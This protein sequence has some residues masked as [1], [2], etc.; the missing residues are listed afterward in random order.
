MAQPT[1]SDVHVDSIL[2]SVSVAY[3]QSQMA[4]IARRVFPL[5]PVAKQ[6]DKYYVYGA[7]AWVR[8]EAQ[9]RAP[10]TESAGGGWTVSTDSYYA[11]VYAIHKDIDEQLVANADGN[12]DPEGEAA[13]YVVDQILRKMEVDFA[14][15]FLTTGVWGSSVTPGTLWDNVASDP[16]WDIALGKRTVL[17]NTGFEPNVGVTTP[18]VFDALRLHPDVKDQFKHTTSESITADMLARV[19]GLD[20]LI[21]SK[22]IKAT[23]NE[24][25]TLATSFI[26]GKHLLLAYRARTPGLLTPSAG[27]C[28]SWQGLIGGSEGYRTKRFPRPE[29]SAVRVEGEAAFDM[30][31]V[32]SSLGYFL[33]SVVS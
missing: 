10:G 21:V 2:T 30:K 20:E 5:V 7:E 32:G 18:P 23:N 17:V 24:G 31:V 8:D 9:K 15:T 6:S 16:L 26:G 28:F 29:L 11:D 3:M 4:N 22:A 12:M 13:R 1:P 33:E 14:S 27:Y 25:A 19:F